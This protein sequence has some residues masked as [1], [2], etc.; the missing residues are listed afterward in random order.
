MEGHGDYLFRDNPH[1][2]ALAR[3]QA[4]FAV[5]GRYGDMS[6]ALSE[7]LMSPFLSRAG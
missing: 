6:E 7:G 3:W 2:T 5:R 1:V 4:Q